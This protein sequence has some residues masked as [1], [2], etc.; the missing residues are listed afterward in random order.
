MNLDQ[1][2]KTNEQRADRWH[3]GDLH[4][5]TLLEWT[6]AMAGECGEACN[7]AKKIKRITNDL[8][9]K[10]AGLT[11]TDRD[12]LDN[13]LA[14]ECADTIIYALIILSALGFNASTVITRV[15]NQKSV[16]Y[17]FPE[18]AD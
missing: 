5:W 12:R 11:V 6:G 14:N 10:K 7:V 4:Q 13:D 2:Q 3:G 16:E 8:P 9:N 17:G 18:R 1:F 15:F